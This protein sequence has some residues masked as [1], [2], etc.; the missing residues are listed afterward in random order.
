MQ[1]PFGHTL[2]L[3]LTRSSASWLKLGPG[4]AALT[5]ALSAGQVEF[6]LPAL[7]QLLGLWLLVDPILGTLWELAVPQGLWRNISTANLPA[8]PQHGFRLPYTQPGTAGSRLNITLRRYQVW[9]R[10]HY[11]PDSGDNVIAFCMGVALALLIG[12]YLKPAIFWLILLGLGLTLMAGQGNP[13]LAAA[14]GGRF[15]SVVQFLLPW[16]MGALLWSALPPL[17]LILAVCYWVTY[18]GGLR[19]WGRHRRAKLLFVLG[20]VAAIFSLLALRLLPGAA[21]LSVLLIAQYLLMSRLRHD[22]AE[23][24]VK[25]QPYLIVGLITVGLSTGSL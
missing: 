16:A 25:V 9:W 15:Q 4:W 19:M 18:L 24:L 2:K 17:S 7:W 23:F 8:P 22:N 3:S 10:D 12:F 21:L 1:R 14:T 11:W 20:Q 5:G 13:A 6:S